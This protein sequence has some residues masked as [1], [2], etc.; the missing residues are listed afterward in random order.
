MSRISADTISFLR[1]LDQQRP[2]TLRELVRLYALDA[3]VLIQRLYGAHTLH[4][5]D[6]LRQAAHYLRSSSLALGF[7]SIEKAAFAIEHDEDATFADAAFSDRLHTLKEQV[8][9]AAQE[10]LQLID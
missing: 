10:L 9:A 3:P 2:G 1:S 6:A 7:E 5:W 8:E 4:D